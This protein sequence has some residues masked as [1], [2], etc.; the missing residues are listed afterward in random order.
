MTYTGRTGD[1]IPL[2]VEFQANG[3]GSVGDPFRNVADIQNIA[4][5]DVF[6]GA[7]GTVTTGTSAQALPSV[8]ASGGIITL[9]N[10]DAGN[11]YLADV[12]QVGLDLTA[13]A[14]NAYV[15]P[16]GIAEPIPVDNANRICV[17][18]DNN[19]AAFTLFGTSFT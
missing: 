18:S 2:Q 8:A 4:Q 17:G 15:I 13:P 3:A 14:S 1:T 10:L 7:S 19:G 6:T 5:P 12:S 9:R 11:L 16:T